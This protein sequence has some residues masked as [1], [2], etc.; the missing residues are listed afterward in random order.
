MPSAIHDFTSRRFCAAIHRKVSN[1]P[2][3]DWDSVTDVGST[4]FHDAS[5]RGKEGDDGLRC[6]S[7]IGGQAWP[8]L[9]IEVGYSESLRQL[10]MDVEWWLLSS[11]GDTKLTILI[12]ARLNPNSFHIEVWMMDPNPGCI[13]GPSLGTRPIRTRSIDID[14]TGAVTPPNGTLTI[15]YDALFDNPNANGTDIILT[16]KDLSLI[17]SA[18]FEQ[19][20]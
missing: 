14:A 18:I 19:A 17:A 15:P 12:L 4:R 3:H 9:M 5:G 16:A 10:R 2:G 7:R 11:G 13:T 6:L 8:N 20:R 1:I